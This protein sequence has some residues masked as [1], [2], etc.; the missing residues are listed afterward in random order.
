MNSAEPY[1]K[2]KSYKLLL[3]IV[4]HILHTFFLFYA[5]SHNFFLFFFSLLSLCFC[6]LLV[7]CFTLSPLF[8]FFVL[9]GTGLSC[10]FFTNQKKTFFF[11]LVLS[12]I[13]HYVRRFK[14]LEFPHNSQRKADT[15]LWSHCCMTVE[16][17]Y[18]HE[19]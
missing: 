11:H 8:A 6:L 10:I 4:S 19:G 12:Q 2:I 15:V 5:Q 7:M 1:W 17:Y 9:N 3:S 14:T 13:L 16:I 18:T